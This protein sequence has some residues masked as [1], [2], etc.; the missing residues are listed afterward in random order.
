VETK[1]KQELKGMIEALNREE[2][3]AEDA[4]LLAEL[5]DEKGNLKVDLS[6]PDDYELEV[7]AQQ[8]L[9]HITSYAQNKKAYLAA[10]NSGDQAR[11]T[12]LWQQL[13]YNQLTAAI[14]Q[15]SYPKAKRVA[16]EL[17]RL[18]ARQAQQNRARQLEED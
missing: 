1:E 10:K 12:Q 13:Q 17:A 14:I 16:D 5:L 7:M 3:T 18:Q 8:L 4:L 6:L 2:E 11:R 15:K 9:A